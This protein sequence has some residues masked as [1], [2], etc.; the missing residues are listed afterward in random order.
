MNTGAVVVVS[1]PSGAGKGTLI[2][3]LLAA[4][5]ELS[6]AVSATTRAPR[7]GEVHGREYY[8]LSQGEFDERIAAGDFVE[9]CHVHG[10]RYGTLRSEIDKKVQAGENVVLEIDIQGAK[11]VLSQ[12]DRLFRVFIAPPSVDILLQRLKNRNTEADQDLDVRMRAA[13][14]EMLEQ[15]FYDGVVVNHEVSRAVSD[16]VQYVDG[17]I[18]KE[19]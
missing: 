12:F 5:P 9:W 15:R 7:E 1:G 19:R 16:L 18:T 8:F 11:K 10:N 4:R 17:F 13:A 2:R 6:L 14:E 3:G